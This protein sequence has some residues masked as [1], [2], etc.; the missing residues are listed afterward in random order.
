MTIKSKLYFKTILKKNQ[1]KLIKQTKKSFNF[2]LMKVFGNA[3]QNDVL[4]LTK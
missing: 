3:E 4:C 2:I 1:P